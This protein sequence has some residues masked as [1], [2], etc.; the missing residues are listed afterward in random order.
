MCL[1]K[2]TKRIAKPTKEE[3][4]GWKSV[5]EGV[6]GWKSVK[7]GGYSDLIRMNFWHF[8]RKKPIKTNVWLKAREVNLRAYESDEKYK[9]GFHFYKT[10]K[11]ARKNG[12]LWAKVV[13]I[14][15]RYVHTKGMQGGVRVWV[16]KEIK[17]IA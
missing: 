4:T 5:K 17:F 9:S 11:E 10:K 14:R 1:G 15:A 12:P 13:K 2:I 3:V 7:E 8:P 16:A 6:T